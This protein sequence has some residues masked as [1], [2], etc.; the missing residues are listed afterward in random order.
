MA[1][2]WPLN[3]IVFVSGRKQ[4]SIILIVFDYETTR[5]PGA[6]GQAVLDERLKGLSCLGV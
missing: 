1:L 4:N 2:K 6:G 5:P 3:N